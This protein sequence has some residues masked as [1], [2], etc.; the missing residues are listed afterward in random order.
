MIG[1]MPS[2]P[3]SKKQTAAML[4]NRPISLTLVCSKVMEHILHSQIM[5]YMEAHD[6][7]TDHQHSFRTRRSC[8]SQLILTVL[9]F[10]VGIH[11]GEQIDAV[12]LDFLK[13]FKAASP[14]CFRDQCF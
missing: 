7:T 11:D 8:E 3:S 6:T 5:K 9:D 4:Q 12:L 1:N 13:V 2:L 10:A 14:S